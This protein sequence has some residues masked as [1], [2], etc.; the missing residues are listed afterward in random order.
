[1][2]SARRAG[3]PITASIVSAGTAPGRYRTGISPV[4]STTVDS[5]PC[6]VGP[7]SR[8]IAILSPKSAATCSARVALT[9]PERFADGAASGRSTA[10]KSCRATG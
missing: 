9:C 4:A 2:C 10:A 6:A 3:R 7:A 5:R 1:M 8:I